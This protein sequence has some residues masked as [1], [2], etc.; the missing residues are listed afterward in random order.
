MLQD[1]F[2]LLKIPMGTLKNFFEICSRALG[3]VHHPWSKMWVYTAA[4]LLGLQVRM[5]LGERNVS[6]VSFVCIVR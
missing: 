1:L 3:K 4:R 2:L 5:P 6:L